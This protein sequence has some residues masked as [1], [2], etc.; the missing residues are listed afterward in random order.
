MS[1]ASEMS[2]AE[3]QACGC[4]DGTV[5]TTPVEIENPPGLATINYRIGTHARFKQSML[6]RL[7]AS[8][9]PALAGLRTRVD[10]DFSVA[11]LDAWATVADVLTFYQERIANESYLRTATER[12]SLLE[13]ARLIGYELRPGV[14]ASTYLAFTV[15][16]SPGVPALAPKRAPVERGTR[17]QSIPAP[18]EKPQTFE[19]VERI[20][21]RVEWNA[22]RP[23][24][25]KRHPIIGDTREPL[26]FEGLATG[27]KPSDGLLL[28]SDAA[29]TPVFR[30]V[31]SVTLQPTQQ[32]T[33]VR[34]VDLT[35]APARTVPKT[36]GVLSTVAS[37]AATTI[38]TLGSRGIG[39][40]TIK[41][42]VTAVKL[43]ASAVVSG[44]GVREVFANQ[45]ATRAPSPAVMAFRTRAAI[46]GHNA[47]KFDY[48]SVSQRKGEFLG[49]DAS[50]T[51]IYQ[52][53]PGQYEERDGSQ[54]K[55][56][57][58]TLDNYHIEPAP[59]IYLDNIYP[60]VVPQGWV[61]LKDGAD[62]KTY[63]VVDV[64]EMSVSDFTL[65]AKVTRLKLDPPAG[66]G[67]F[68]IR[69]TTV[70][71]QSEEM[72]LARLPI[73]EP[74]SGTRIELDGLVDGLGVGQSVVVCGVLSGMLGVTT[75]EHATLVQIEHQMDS[76][77]YTTITIGS[78]ANIY[79]RDTV[80]IY[81]NVARATHGEVVGEALGSGD[82][83][84][85]YQ[86]FSLRQPPLT[87]VQ[88]PIA[89][90]AAATL[91]VRVNDLLWREVPSLHGRS[92]TEH[93]YI[94]RLADDGTT[95]IEFGDGSTGARLPTG[96]Q[97][98]RATY[99]KGIGIGGL[100]EA[101]QLS[102]LLTRPLGIKGV[103]NPL[104]A[105]GAADRESLSDARRNAPLTVLTLDRAVSLKDYEDFASSFAGIG[106]AFATWSWEGRARSVFITVAGSNGL[107]VKPDSSTYVN[108]L[109]ALAALGDPFASLHVKSYRRALFRITGRVTVGAEYVPQKV[110]AAIEAG[111]RQAFCFET[112]SFG[113]PVLLSEVI[114]GIHAVDGVVAVDIDTFH[115]TGD[116][117]RPPG[118][119]LNAAL[120][121]AGENGVPEA[122]E[123]LT[124]DPGPLELS[125][126]L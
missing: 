70:F 97:N 125:V 21:A 17:V 6:A 68:S 72:K 12:R 107:G 10:E 86:Q 2:S 30:Q 33:E 106:K 95:S 35:A 117:P 57:D 41:G 98:V 52:H 110:K 36:I 64:S 115:R 18:D 113:Q 84:Q 92:P 28:V 9:R 121:T 69:G 67:S 45:R 63:S 74:V 5:A 99:R 78:L 34:L 105:E 1:A 50:R 22:M 54:T 24:L 75:C 16:D 102:M 88:A 47:P 39:T 100:V 81:A 79:V 118:S 93:V 15:E 7:S 119:R 43:H 56:V 126:T 62:L 61:V 120:P 122:A 40:T 20:E 112:R 27:L 49:P 71:A 48:L 4:C 55:W 101:G 94:T 85:S 32:R 91:E 59:S 87:Y 65:N 38:Q 11:L 124:L 37:A 89:S 82:A 83:S 29:S 96:R 51:P 103:T 73:P 116:Q 58:T 90:G 77:G 76:E 25:T 3:L 23:R 19:T 46:F 108:L 14:A 8:G 104:A 42:T 31:Q 60:T 111:L 80:V 109:A 53:I 123:L 26:L 13:L 114:A 66:F 44:F